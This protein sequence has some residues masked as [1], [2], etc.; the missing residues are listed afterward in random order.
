M[1]ENI[2]VVSMVTL[3]IGIVVLGKGPVPSH[4]TH[5]IVNSSGY[6]TTSLMSTPIPTINRHISTVIPLRHNNSAFVS[7]PVCSSFSKSIGAFSR[8]YEFANCFFSLLDFVDK[9]EMLDLVNMVELSSLC[10][11][12]LSLLLLISAAIRNAMIKSIPF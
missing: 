6:L 9:V 7:S 1:F 10:P 4:G 11:K 5:N 2:V 12:P 8:V 3:H